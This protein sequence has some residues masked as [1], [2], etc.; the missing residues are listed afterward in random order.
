[1]RA[2]DPDTWAPTTD[3]SSRRGAA[4]ARRASISKGYRVDL[5][6]YRL[7]RF[8]N[9]PRHR[10]LARSLARSL[11]RASYLFIYFVHLI[12]WPVARIPNHGHRERL[13]SWG[14]P[15]SGFEGQVLKE[16]N[17]TAHTYTMTSDIIISY[18]DAYDSITNS[19][20]QISSYYTATRLCRDDSL[21]TDWGWLNF[22]R[23]SDLRPTK[24]EGR[25]PP[26]GRG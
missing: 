12:P 4:G 17:T 5:E 11:V 19:R 9:A 7:P 22:S 21:T 18:R 15:R 26:W 25:T 13:P 23:R 6:S 20:V 2:V 3:V 16:A 10:T 24:I 14:E 8:Q 1:M